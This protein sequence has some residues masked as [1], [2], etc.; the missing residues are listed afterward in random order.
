MSVL[1]GAVDSVKCERSHDP[2]PSAIDETLVAN[3]VKRKASE[4]LESPSV[5]VNSPLK[6]TPS[7]SLPALPSVLGLKKISF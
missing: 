1:H 6:D 3:C 2:S 5:I 7:G 4:T